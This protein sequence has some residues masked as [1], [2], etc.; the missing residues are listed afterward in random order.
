MRTCVHQA[1]HAKKKALAHS[2]THHVPF[3]FD[4]D[5]KFLPGN[6]L[7]AV[8]RQTPRVTPKVY[9]SRDP[10]TAWM[11]ENTTT[12]HR[13]RRLRSSVSTRRGRSP[14]NN[15]HDQRVGAARWTRRSPRVS[16]RV[17][18]TRSAD[19]RRMSSL[20]KLGH[21]MACG[22]SEES[23]SDTDGG[24]SSHTMRQQ[25]Q[26]GTRGLQEEAHYR[27]NVLQEETQYRTRYR[28]AFLAE[29]TRER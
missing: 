2:S 29:Q 19:L 14:R 18:S 10:V 4:M 23:F 7:Y 27:A 16:M 12:R 15:R 8:N 28:A 6:P 26:Y 3:R 25:T 1:G 17:R 22:S 21:E 5:V 20:R 9:V 24:S 13:R 11:D